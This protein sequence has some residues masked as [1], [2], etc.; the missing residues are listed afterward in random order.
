MVDKLWVLSRSSWSRL[1]LLV[2][3]TSLTLVWGCSG[4]DKSIVIE[5]P[6][7]AGTASGPTSA[8]T[9]STT[10]CASYV[11]GSNASM[12]GTLSNGN[13]IYGSDFVSENNPLT[14]DV[15][16]KDFDGVHIFQATLQVGVDRSNGVIP[17][18]PTLTVEAGATLAWTNAADYLL[19]TRGSKIKALGSRSAPIT[20][21]AY[22]DAVSGTVAPF[23]TQLWGGVVINGRGVTNKCDNEQR[24]SHT[25]HIQSEGKPS[26][27]GGSDNSD[28]SGSLRYVVIKYPGFEVAPG[29]ELN[30]LTL[31]TVGSETVINNLQVY[32]AFDDGVE[33]FGGAVDVNNFIALYVRDDSI[34]YADGWI[35]SITNSLIIHSENDGNRCIEGDN[36]GAAY[37]ALPRTHPRVSNMTCITS[38]NVSGTHGD[39]E[40]VLFRR[41]VSTA[42]ANSIIYDGYGRKA[43]SNAGNECL[44]LDDT[45]TRD[46]AQQGSMSIKSTAIV[47]NEPTKDALGN[48]DSVR[49]WAMN[50][51]SGSYP[52]NTDNIIWTASDD[53]DVEVIGGLKGYFTLPSF[54]DAD[55]NSV[56]ITSTNGL[57]IGAVSASN[58]WTAD[59]SVCLVPRVE[60]ACGLYFL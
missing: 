52:N 13:C 39:S 58:D 12:R 1:E 18:G 21:T 15:T 36:Q 57:P 16:F 22:E 7:P 45:P 47:C 27:Y 4:G 23:A 51:G 32:S 14:T 40:G 53:A 59:W 26:H 34:D 31:N 6:P 5:L 20:F 60:N 25:C 55:G 9:P 30:G 29:D 35:G 17:D 24:S 49:Q 28:N 41:G 50:N 11:D 42:L 3:I 33:F 44:E 19:I 43:L 37:D 48:G 8:N 2:L 46:N 54:T 38:G 56:S 10:P